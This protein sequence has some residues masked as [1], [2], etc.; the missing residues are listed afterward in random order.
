MNKVNSILQEVLEKIEPPS[1]DLKFIDKSLKENISKIKSNIK[2]LKLK[3][4]DLFVGGS[5]AKGTVI[6]KDYYDVDL[7][8]RFGKK[9]KSGDF[10]KLTE[11]I[12]SGMKP[13]KIHGSRDYFR[14]IIRDDF[15]IEVVPVRKISKLKDAENITDLSYSHV[16]YIKK[17]VKT[18]KIKDGIRLAKAFCYATKTY[19][20]ESYINGFSGYALELLVYH[21]KGFLNFL[22]AVSKLDGNKEVIDIERDYRN[23]NQVLMDVNQSKLNSPIILI[24]PTYKQRNAL[25]ALSDETLRRFQKAA[26]DFL[27]KPSLNAFEME[28]KD[29]EAIEN[30]AK[31]KKLEFVK[32]KISTERQKGDIAGSKMLKFFKYLGNEI[33]KLF[34]IKHNG[35]EYDGNKSAIAYF[36]VKPKKEIIFNGPRVKDEKNVSA[37][38]RKHKKTFVKSGRVYAKE[39][40]DYSLKKFLENFVKNKQGKKRMEE[41]NISKLEI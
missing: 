24:D 35:F 26:K 11:K 13:E 14:I 40:I 34:E 25:A 32:L 4:V 22:K 16:N 27:S 7:F 2:K 30:S 12:L 31:K 9:H 37:F 33:I 29:L 8:V 39:K 18:Q 23:R 38:K 17:K 19:G 20:A 5:F 1:E 3:D 36:V 21:Y 10:A 28:K 6:K 41:M 15:F